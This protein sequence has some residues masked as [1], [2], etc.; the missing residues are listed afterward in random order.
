MNP[1]ECGQQIVDA[2]QRANGRWAKKVQGL[3][4]NLKWDNPL[5]L[6]EITQRL[7]TILDEMSEKIPGKV[8]DEVEELMEARKKT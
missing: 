2:V 5:T 1:Y 4:N 6:N 8:R 7:Q 3:L